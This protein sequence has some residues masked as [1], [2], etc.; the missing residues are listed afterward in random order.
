MRV[1]DEHTSTCA[2]VLIPLLIV[3]I[4][5]VALFPDFVFHGDNGNGN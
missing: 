4:L 1:Q 2:L 3:M 5:M